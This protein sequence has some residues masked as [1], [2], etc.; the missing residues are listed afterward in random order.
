MSNKRGKYFTAYPKGGFDN[1]FQTYDKNFQQNL[2]RP[3]EPFI[4]NVDT[5]MRDQ[6]KRDEVTG[7]QPIA[8]AFPPH[9]FIP[10]DSQSLDMRSGFVS[11]PPLLTTDVLTFVAP[12]GMS[13]KF[14]KYAFISEDSTDLLMIPTVNRQ[15]V[16]PYHGTPTS[17]PLKSFEMR[18]G[19]GLGSV[20]DIALIECQ[21]DIN[22]GEVFRWTV[23]NS[24]VV[25]RGV[26]VR[27]VG[28]IS[29]SIIRKTRRFGG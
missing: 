17:S 2:N 5:S 8:T 4:N 22:P 12:K 25:A 26:S 10:E 19:A 6:E 24:G 21:L 29:Q 23:Q 28:Y 13:S 16:L 18:F 15:R 14:L 11:V 1:P 7:E 3:Y 27:L 20:D 9:L